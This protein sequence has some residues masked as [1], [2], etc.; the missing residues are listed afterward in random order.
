MTNF[1]CAALLFENLSDLTSRD[2]NL[3]HR[4]ALMGAVA[5]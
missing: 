4:Q 2:N 5:C 1:P 3:A